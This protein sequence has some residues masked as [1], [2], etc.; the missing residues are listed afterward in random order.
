MDANPSTAGGQARNVDQELLYREIASL[1]T[2]LI[3]CAR[4]MN[5][6]RHLGVAVS[7]LV[8]SVLADAF[9]K[10][11][12]GDAKLVFRSSGELRSW[13]VERLQWNYKDRMKRRLRYGEILASLTPPPS[14]RTP[15]NE[16]ASGETALR[17]RE[18]LDQLDSGDRQVIDARVFEGLRFREIARRHGYSTSYARRVWLRAIA[19]VRSRYP[20]LDKLLAR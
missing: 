19:R 7:D 9:E 12:D 15:S 5:G 3:V 11:A 14:P 10:V 2:Y 13:L 16:A 8:D 1:R 17:V 20:S 18:V 4:S 6:I